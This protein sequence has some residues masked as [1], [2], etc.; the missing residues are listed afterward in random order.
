VAHIYSVQPMP[1]LFRVKLNMQSLMISKIGHF[2]LGGILPVNWH[3][4][5][6]LIGRLHHKCIEL[7]NGML[8]NHHVLLVIVILYD[9]HEIKKKT[10]QFA[11]NDKW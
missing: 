7:V 2:P 1:G 6:I 9:L 4:R 3:F 8:M 11:D 5:S 10:K